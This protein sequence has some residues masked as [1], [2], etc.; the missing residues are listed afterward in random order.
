MLSKS[1]VAQA[2]IVTQSAEF[3]RDAVVY[4]LHLS[5]S[6]HICSSV[7]DAEISFQHSVPP[8]VYGFTEEQWRDPDACLSQDVYDHERV[9]DPIFDAVVEDLTAQA[10]AWSEDFESFS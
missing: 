2:L 10:N 3:E 9:G 8:E 5:A 1:S 6:G 7:R 4:Y